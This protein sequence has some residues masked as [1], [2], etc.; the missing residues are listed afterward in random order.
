M[1]IL[2]PLLLAAAPAAGDFAGLTPGH[3][4]L[5]EAERAL[6]APRQQA[7][8]LTCDGAAFGA[9]E[10]R[11]QADP[12][13]G[14]VEWIGVGLTEPAPAATVCG[15]LGLDPA[16]G[17][18]L[19]ADPSE[20]V[21]LF[22]SAGLALRS[23]NGPVTH[24]IHLAPDRVDE[25]AGEAAGEEREPGPA[26]WRERAESLLDA[27]DARGAA[28]AVWRAIELDPSDERAELVRYLA[29]AALALDPTPSGTLGL[30]HSGRRVLELVPGGPADRAGVRPGDLVLAV[31]GEPIES[32]RDLLD[33]LAELKPGVV[34]LVLERD[35]R[36]VDPT[37]TVPV[38]W[39]AWNE[40][41]EPADDLERYLRL[42]TGGEDAEAGR[43]IDEL[44]DRGDL[45]GGDAARAALLHAARDERAHP[46]DGLARWRAWLERHGADAP[47]W[48]DTHASERIAV[49]EVQAR[50]LREAAD[51]YR[52]GEHGEVL[53]TLA[54]MES[55][56][57]ALGHFLVG[58]SRRGTKEW[59][60]AEE[61]LLRSLRL[62]PAN[63]A[64]WHVLAE[65][66]LEWD[67]Y[68]AH[69]ASRGVV[70]LTEE[71]ADGKER[72]WRRRAVERCER[73]RAAA[74]RQVLAGRAR[75]LGLR[76]QALTDLEAALER[77]PECAALRLRRA[78]LLGREGD[79][80]G[81]RRE[82]ERALER[83]ETPLSG[84]AWR[85][86]ALVH[87]RAGDLE[88]AERC[89]S[90]ALERGN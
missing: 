89:W 5:D 70:L 18:A 57:S 1:S 52:R 65:T 45:A 55:E 66:Y 67:V 32:T 68:R 50:H 26:Y 49:L 17:L 35:G 76:A 7:G 9:A 43:L 60:H 33:V 82:I 63:P 53:A 59:V 19:P 87:E 12:A 74:A 84:A 6:G 25:L 11:V 39:E 38:T 90:E 77:V 44:A 36:W 31:G 23:G 8:L 64:I 73:V 86:L 48:M 4:T 34:S 54:A 75:S 15:W 78:D 29:G 22:P 47:A 20:Q 24:V 46:V 13:T 27:G 42:A 72:D 28:D 83:G 41:P 62:D 14:I 3:S 80:E 69:A 16:D 81:A 51:P 2:V 21:T 58:L 10:I 71:A 85:L 30:I 88:A 40:L 79:V 56:P 61:E 37:A